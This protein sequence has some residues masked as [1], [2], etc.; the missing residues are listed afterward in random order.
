MFRKHKHRRKSYIKRQKSS[1]KLVQIKVRLQPSLTRHRIVSLKF[2]NSQFEGEKN[3]KFAYADMHGALKAILNT[4]VRN[5][6]ILEFKTKMEVMEILNLADGLDEDA[7][8][9]IYE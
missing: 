4:P 7:Y 5:T 1:G 8:E 6:S 9:G 2:V 3:I